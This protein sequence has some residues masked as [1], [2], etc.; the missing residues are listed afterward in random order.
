MHRIYLTERKIARFQ[1]L[2]NL[3]IYQVRQSPPP[4]RFQ[5]EIDSLFALNVDDSSRPVVIPDNPW[6]GTRQDFT[7]R[8]YF[9][10]PKEWRSPVVLILPIGN[11]RCGVKEFKAHFNCGPAIHDQ[12]YFPPTLARQLD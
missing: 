3:R 12:E 5:A 8:T 10:V 4:F 6:A 1:E 9:T 2:L 11:D 7:L